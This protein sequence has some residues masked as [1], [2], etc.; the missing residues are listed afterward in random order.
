MSKKTNPELKKSRVR[1]RRQYRALLGLCLDCLAPRANGL[2]R[3]ER[4]V[5]M[6]TETD[7]RALERKVQAR[8]YKMER[9][10]YNEP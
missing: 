2:S 5:T 9:R 3:C 7:R 6:H 10:Y 4:H 8:G 1:E